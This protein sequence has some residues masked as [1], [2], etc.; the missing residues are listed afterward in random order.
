MTAGAAVLERES[1]RVAGPRPASRSRL[2]L[3]AAAWLAAGALTGVQ[4][5][6]LAALHGTPASLVGQVVA[7]TLG[8]AAWLPVGALVALAARRAPLDGR[9][10]PRHLPLHLAG[11]AAVSFVVN[12]VITALW[13]VAGVPLSEGFWGTTVAKSLAFLHLNALMYWLIVAA[14]HVAAYHQAA[15]ARELRLARVEG[16]LAEARLHAL[17]AQ[18]HPHFLF[19]ALH[20]VG[21][22]WRTN[23]AGEAYDTLERL[24]AILRRMLDGSGEAEVPLGEELDFVREYLAVERSRLR[25]RLRVEIDVPAEVLGA[26]VPALLLQPLVENAVRHGIAPHSSAGRLTV[27]AWRAGAMLHITVGDDGPGLSPAARSGG[28]G[29]GLRNTRERLLHLHGERQHLFLGD[30]PEGGCLVE[31]EM[32]YQVPDGGR[33]PR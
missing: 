17:R 5:W 6:L 3:L 4:F 9:R 31:V 2:G 27:R 24:G 12:L 14:V 29:V 13:W 8:A 1:G 19:N 26:R 25:D 21:M 32:P 23:R 7:Q 30:A 10:W 22:L 16:Q 11:A 20:T 18:L 15:R 33:G 28:E